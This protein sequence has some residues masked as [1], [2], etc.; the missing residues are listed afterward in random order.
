M[1]IGIIGLGGAGRAHHR[2]FRTNKHIGKILAYDVKEVNLPGIERVKEL[3]HM[4]AQVDAV[5]ITSPDYEHAA[6]IA[7]CFKRG[8]H[9]LV[10]KPMVANL[11]EANAL[12]DLITGRPEQVFAVHH[13]MRYIP[14]FYKAKEIIAS[15]VLGRL[16]YLEAS[17]WHDMRKRST[18]FDDWR[19]RGL[20][21]SVIFAHGCHSYDLLMYLLDDYPTAHS[22]YV[23]KNAFAQ[24]PQPYTAA[25]T[26]MKFPGD[27]IGKVHVNNCSVFPQTNNLIILGDR[28]SYVDGLLFSADGSRQVADYDFSLGNKNS[29][30]VIA[31]LIARGALGLVERFFTKQSLWRFHPLSVY[32]HEHACQVIIDDFIEAVLHKRPPLVGFQEARRVIRLCGELEQSVTQS[33]VRS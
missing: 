14:A 11:A 29:L 20:G 26:M 23:N 10:E 25:T 12:E 16:F 6:D 8:K 15:G 22:T 21:Q 1:N 2:R 28:G 13:Q 27:I 4:L 18:Q 17:Y 5:S 31:R 33:E 19:M 30:Q 3:E 32:N 24:Y 9:V 7:L